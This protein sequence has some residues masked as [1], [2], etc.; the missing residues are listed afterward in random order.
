MPRESG[1]SIQTR[2]S[3]K[4]TR[5]P[6]THQFAL[7]TEGGKDHPA[8]GRKCCSSIQGAEAPEVALFIMIRLCGEMDDREERPHA[9]AHFFLW[10]IP[11]RETGFL[12]PRANKSLLAPRTEKKR[13]RRGTESFDEIP[14][15]FDI[16]RSCSNDPFGF[17]SK[18][19]GGAKPIRN[20]RVR[21]RNVPENFLQTVHF[22]SLRVANTSVRSSKEREKLQKPFADAGSRTLTGGR[23]GTEIRH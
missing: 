22:P 10:P 12:R 15:I 6:F 1:G 11:R 5:G 14:A 18:R 17:R 8:S 2:P 19:G 9:N 3:T 4:A 23:G 21:C 16:V 13:G 7:S 20:I